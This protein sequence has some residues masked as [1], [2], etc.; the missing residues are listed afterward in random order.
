MANRLNNHR[1]A[2]A[3]SPCA[4][5][6]AADFARLCRRLLS[7]AE[8]PFVQ[9][10]ERLL[11][12]RGG[13]LAVE[14][15]DHPL[16]D[17]PHIHHAVAECFG[18]WKLVAE[19]GPPQPSV[20]TLW[21]PVRT[22]VEVARGRF[23]DF[24]SDGSRFYRLPD[25]S[26]RVLGFAPS[27]RCDEPCIRFLMVGRRRDREALAADCERL[28][29]RMAGAHYLQ[30]QV[31]TADGRILPDFQPR[32]WDDVA[33]IAEVR[34]TIL[35]NTVEVLRR[36]E[37]F[38]RNGVPLKRGLILHGPPGTGKTLVGKALAGMNLGTFIYVTASDASRMCTFRGVFALARRLRPTIVFLEDMDL[39]PRSATGSD[40][41]RCWAR[42][43]PSST[44][45][46]RTTA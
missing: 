24:V 45:W 21:A 9:R 13:K 43:W 16:Y 31:L 26:H 44:D 22:R 30:G 10:V 41:R 12:A 17:L 7:R 39:S 23:D 38:R 5:G 40:H 20:R 6:D 27:E 2:L 15:G 19:G 3:A 36:S 11:G 37:A 8:S 14:A 33:L 1:T 28:R 29:E 32:G 34:E 42:C 35:R 25:G 46:S 18:D 4:A